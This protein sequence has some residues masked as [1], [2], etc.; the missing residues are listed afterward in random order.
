MEKPTIDPFNAYLFNLP[1]DEQLAGPGSWNAQNSSCGSTPGEPLCQWWDEEAG[2][3]SEEGCETV[4]AAPGSTQ[5]QCMC[6]HLTQFAVL[7]TRGDPGTGSPC[8]DMLRGAALATTKIISV[9]ST[10]GALFFLVVVGATV[11]LVRLAAIAKKPKHITVPMHVCVLVV[12][13]CRLVSSLLYVFDTSGGPVALQGVLISLPAVFRFF[14]FSF[15]G[16]SWIKSLF[17]T[18][19][20]GAEL[21]WIKLRPYFIAAN[22]LVLVFVTLTVVAFGSAMQ[23]LD[24]VDEATL[25]SMETMALIGTILVCVVYVASATA[26]LV[27]G[28]R[29]QMT[30]D[31][32]MSKAQSSSSPSSDKRKAGPSVGQKQL[33]FGAGV[34]IVLV[35]QAALEAAATGATIDMRRS[36]A[37]LAE[38]QEIVLWLTF[39][40]LLLELVSLLIAV[41]FFF[42]AVEKAVWGDKKKP[43]RSSKATL[44]SSS[45]T[46]NMSALTRSG[47]GVT[48]T[49][50]STGISQNGPSWFARLG[51]KFGG[52]E[53]DDVEMMARAQPN[54]AAKEL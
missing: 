50:S 41:W 12:G 46:S 44:N 16:L 2:K 34:T 17:F 24:P 31:V 39:A 5:V 6:S 45:S 1:V 29:M 38:R 8:A 11:Q 47:T 48:L 22:V 9:H 25:A 21:A 54:P 37:G 26:L 23:A 53:S 27:F 18:M 36:G 28:R 30:L 35:L 4:L 10:A 43:A 3:W 13:L 52:K 49:R 7:L 32:G 20:M 42:A 40:Y 15:V 33:I 19:R 51:S 14:I